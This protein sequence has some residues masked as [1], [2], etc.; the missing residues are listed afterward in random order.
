M[1]G[2]MIMTIMT[3]SFPGDA[4]AARTGGRVGRTAYR[5]STSHYFSRPSLRV[6]SKPAAR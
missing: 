2:L 1:L 4:W 5:S 6:V 3:A